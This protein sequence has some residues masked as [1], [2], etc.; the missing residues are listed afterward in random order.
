MREPM[1]SKRGNLVQVGTYLPPELAEQIK[2][3]SQITRV[4]QAAY[5]REAIEDLLRK[6]EEVL[7]GGGRSSGTKP[8]K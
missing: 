8:R 5:F 2:E 4:P 3:L 7:S 1:A 6:Y